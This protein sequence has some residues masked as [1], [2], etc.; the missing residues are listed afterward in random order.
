MNLAINCARSLGA[1]RPMWHSTGFTPANLLLDADMRQA[2][3]YLGAIP[4]QGITWVRI[5]YLLELVTADGLGSPHPTYDWSR[6]DRALDVLV[7][8]RLKPFFEL[9]GFPGGTTAFSDF[10]D[11]SQAQAWRHLVGELARHLIARYGQDEV[12]SW[13]FETWN[14]PDVGFW[15]QG[16]AAFCIYYDACSAGLADV[17]PQLRLGGPG[18]CRHLSSTL[19]TF[20]AHCDTGTN[21][22]TGAPARR[23]AFISVHEKGVRAHR[24]DLTPD[25]M[26]IVEREARIIDYIRSH[27]PALA[28]LPFTNNEPDPQVGWGTIH[29]WRARPYYAAL[30]TK[31]IHQHLVKLVDERNVDYLFLSNDNGFLGTWG[32]RTLLTRFSEHDHIDHGQADGQRDAPRLEEDPRRRRFDLIKKPIL[33][34]MTLLSLLGDERCA[35]TGAPDV[36]SPLGIIA[37]RRGDGQIAILLYNSDDRSTAGGSTTHVALHLEGIPFERAMLTHYAIGGEAED[38]FSVWERMGAPDRPTATQLAALRDRHELQTTGP[39]CEVDCDD[40][41]FSYTLDLALPS[42]AVLLLTADPGVAPGRVSGL[43]AERYQ[44][45]QGEEQILLMWDGVGSRALSTY[46][47]LFAPAPGD[48]ASDE[49]IR[50]NN[51]DLL[52]TAF[53][54]AQPRHGS[55]RVRAL[56]P[57]AR[58]GEPSDPII[59]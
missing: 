34:L 18:T 47:V 46:E 16:D 50:L 14:E 43:S 8:H 22:L 9:M 28:D 1:L 41:R 51:A 19:L 2:M 36:A 32:H 35:V 24:E 52:D 15:Q 44:N 38:P 45:T 5:H 42:V 57:W 23:P 58:Y 33:N 10:T 56:D 20:L 54:V 48:T 49:T 30:V 3:A 13:L 29:T 12:R 39:A 40:G 37:T 31:V 59:I 26:G 17:D 4:H 7:D 6:L 11:L 25:T 27:H 55:Y 21:A 53:L